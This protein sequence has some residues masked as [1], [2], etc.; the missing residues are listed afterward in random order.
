MVALCKILC[1]SDIRR[2]AAVNLLRVFRLIHCQLARNR[3]G[4][5]GHSPGRY[6]TNRGNSCLDK[7]IRSSSSLVTHTNNLVHQRI[8]SCP[9]LPHAIPDLPAITTDVRHFRE[10]ESELGYAENQIEVERRS[11]S[12]NRK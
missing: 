2:Q 11:R 9:S 1:R 3:R 6:G 8:K 5:W 7:S 12:V 4:A 10:G